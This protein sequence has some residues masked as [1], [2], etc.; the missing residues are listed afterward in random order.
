MGGGG[1][2]GGAN[3]LLS[4]TTS[5]RPSNVYTNL[6]L[7]NCMETLLN[8]STSIVM[9]S[10]PSFTPR[11]SIS[12]GIGGS[13]R[14]SPS[15]VDSTNTRIVDAPLKREESAGI[16]IPPAS[17]TSPRHGPISGI[18]AAGGFMMTTNS[19]PSGRY[20]SQSN[21][22]YGSPGSSPIHTIHTAPT[23]GTNYLEVY[24]GGGG[25]GGGGVGGGGGGGLLAGSYTAGTG[26]ISR[27]VSPNP[28]MS[29]PSPCSGVGEN[30]LDSKSATNQKSKLM[31][32]YVFYLLSILIT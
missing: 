27:A 28:S 6:A 10:S 30:R 18:Q 11:G 16:P 24:G 8:T 3:Q 2:G 29:T 7:G 21:H 5:A 4:A 22:M 26:P 32:R 1:G 19:P 20:S 17:A 15:F 25:C 13:Y 14:P 31:F 12:S 9:P 23:I